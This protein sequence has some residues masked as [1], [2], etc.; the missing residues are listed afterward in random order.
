MHSTTL[1]EKA[2]ELEFSSTLMFQYDN[3]SLNQVHNT[4]RQENMI[5]DV[6]IGIRKDTQEHDI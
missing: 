4:F 3:R 5:L 2:A 6:E 1:I